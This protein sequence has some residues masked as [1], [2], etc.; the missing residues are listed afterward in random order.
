MSAYK[1]LPSGL[2]PIVVDGD[3]DIKG[4][5]AIILRN[6]GTATVNLWNGL[7]TLDSKETISFNVVEEHTVLDILNVPVKFDTS[8]GPIKKLQIIVLKRQEAIC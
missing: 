3:I 5:S 4:L 7:Y 6:A 8:S 1:L 2:P